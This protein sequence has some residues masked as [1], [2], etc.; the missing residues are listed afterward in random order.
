MVPTANKKL[1]S[2]VEL[3]G[4]QDFRKLYK[5]FG[6]DAVIESSVRKALAIL[7][8]QSVDVIIAEFN[9]Q[10]TFRDRISSLESV[11][12]VAQRNEN[13][14]FIVLY[15]SEFENHLDKLRA[16]YQFSVE[17]SFPVTEQKMIAAM[18]EISCGR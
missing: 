2:I 16:Q 8:K 11:I 6:Y 12:A 4:Y 18:E 10:H 7:K 3:G 17:I 14:K 5:Q 9:Y 15:E 13:I 1:L